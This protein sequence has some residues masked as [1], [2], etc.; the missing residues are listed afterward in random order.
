MSK[1]DECFN[2]LEDLAKTKGYLLFDE[3]LDATESF[4][5]SI[6]EVDNLSEKLQLNGI[7]ISDEPVINDDEQQLY[8]YSRTDYDAIYKEIASIAPELEYTINRIKDL[9]TPQ[10]GEIGELFAKMEYF[11]YSGAEA[12]SARERLIMLHLRMVLKIAL[13][14]SKLYG[15]DISDT[16]SEGF[17]SLIDAVD[18]FKFTRNDNQYFGSYVGQ[19]IWG[20]IIRECQPQWVHRIPPHLMDNL[21]TLIKMYKD[22]YGIDSEF[23]IPSDEFIKLCANRIDKPIELIKSYWDIIIRE[24]SSLSLEEYVENEDA[25]YY[26]PSL[27]VDYSDEWEEEIWHYYLK[28]IVDNTLSTLTPRQQS[29]IVMRFGLEN[30]SPKSLQAISGILNLTR[31]R[32]RQIES[33][34]L[35]KMRNSTYIQKV[36]SDFL[37]DFYNPTPSKPKRTNST[38]QKPAVKKIKYNIVR[39]R[40]DIIQ[41]ISSGEITSDTQSE[42]DEIRNLSDIHLINVAPQYGI[43]PGNYIVFY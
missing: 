35:E 34:A 18:K 20:S 33:K 7:V 11:N 6:V 14:L 36:K 32:I 43:S 19:Y 12:D 30:H 26:D 8:D 16:I 27:R 22:K 42:I 24:S 29:V 15:Y 28:T 9:P 1:F 31:E 23:E 17:S 37:N 5:L 10:K 21:L 13:P 25:D 39:L 3:I 40:Q 38:S 2:S 4:N 41:V